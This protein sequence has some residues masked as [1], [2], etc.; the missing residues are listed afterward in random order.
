MEN[1]VFYL[2]SSVTRGEGGDTDGISFAESIA[3]KT[4]WSFCK[5]AVSG[6]A[7]ARQ[8]EGDRSYVSRLAKLDF[9]KKPRALVV[10]LST[11]DFSQG[12]PCGS[13]SGCTREE[14]CDASCTTGAIEY[15]LAYVRRRSPETKVILFTCPLT[16]SFGSYAQYAAYVRGTL[17]ELAA[18]HRLC[19]VD[20]F[21]QPFP[22][23]CL[24]PDGLHPTREGYEKLFVPALLNALRKA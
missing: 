22:A 2:G 14:D 23:G 7:L 13:V 9:S 11:N 3:H 17:R 4:G 12:V 6:T 20:L 1:A 5:E 15:I 10:Q 8:N 18:A 21:S 19:V 16:P 24:Q